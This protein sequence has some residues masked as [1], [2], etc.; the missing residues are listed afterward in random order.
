MSK[1]VPV[2]GLIGLAISL[3]IA[4]G[5]S[6][7]ETYVS[8]NI[9]QD[10]TWTEEGSPYIIIR[11]ISVYPSATLTIKPGVKI[12]FDGYYSLQIGGTLVA[13]G[14][15]QKY[16]TFT[17]NKANPSPG[18]W[19]RI[20]FLDSS[21]DARFDDA[22]NYL[23]GSILEYCKIEYGG[24]SRYGNIGVI[25]ADQ[26]ASPAIIRNTISKNAS[27]AV[28]L[29]GNSSSMITSNVITDNSGLGI[30]CPGSSL[31]IENNTISNNATGIWGS[32]KSI[33]NNFIHGNRGGGIGIDADST[34]TNNIILNNTYS[35]I[36]IYSSTSI[37]SGNKVINNGDDGILGTES[38]ALIVNNSIIGNRGYGINCYNDKVENNT[39]TKNKGGIKNALKA[40][41]N[42][43]FDNTDYDYLSSTSTDVDAANNWWG[44]TDTAEID[45][46]IYD[47]W[48]NITLGKVNYPPILDAPNL[49]A[50]PL[51]PTGL[52]ATVEDNKI[53]LT[54]KRSEQN[55]LAGYK[56]YYDTDSGYPYGGKNAAEGDSPI[57]VGNRIS[58][59][60]TGLSDGIYF[61]SIT[62]Y[63]T[64]GNESWHSDEVEIKVGTGVDATPPSG[65]ILINDGAE[66]TNSILVDLTLSAADEGIGMGEGARMRFSNDNKT[67][68]D[69]EPYSTTKA[70]WDL[71]AYGGSPDEGTKTVYAL[72]SDA[73]GNWI[74]RAVSDTI[75]YISGIDTTPPSS[76]I[77]APENGATVSGKVYTIKGTAT[78]DKSGVDLIEVSTDGG[79]SWQKA[80]G[81]TNWQYDW[82]LP[83]DGT[84]TIKSR[85]T[86]KDGNIETPGDG[87]TVIVDNQGISTPTGLT[88]QGGAKSVNLSWKA[89]T[90]SDLAGYN[91][92]REIDPTGNYTTKINQ[93]LIKTTSYTDEAVDQGNT[94]WYKITAVDLSGNESN[95]SAA[96]S[97]KVGAITVWMPDIKGEAG[98]KVSLPINVSN[99]T[100]VGSTAA[101][102][103]IK[104]NYNPNLLT[105]TQ[106][107]TTNLTKGFTLY[108]NIS[109]A[110]GQL[111][112]SGVNRTGSTITGEGYLV[113]VEYSINREAVEGATATL[114]F[115]EV[116][117]Y[118]D[119][120]N[121]LTV[122]Y[123][124][125][126]TFTVG[127]AYKRG[128]LNGDGS[129]DSADALIAMKIATGEIEPSKEQKQAGDIDGNGKIN[130]AD[131]ILILRMAVGL[132]IH[133]SSSVASNVIKALKIFASSH[134][135]NVTIG[136]HPGEAGSAITVPII[137]DNLA[138]VAGAD[139]LL[140]FDPDILTATGAS[141]TSLSTGF[142]L[143][144]KITTGAI[145]ISILSTTELS[146]GSGAFVNVGFQVNQGANIGA[147]TSLTL[148]Q[149]SLYSQYGRDLSLDHSVKATNGKFTVAHSTPT[150]L[151]A[152]VEGK[153]VHIQWQ[154][155][156]EAD[157]DH[158]NIYVGYASKAYDLDGSPFN[159]GNITSI[160]APDVPD[161][162]YYLALSAVNSAGQESSLSEEIKLVVGAKPSITIST[163]KDSYSPGDTLTLSFAI[164]NP[165]A[166]TQVVDIFLGIIAPDGSIYFFDSSPF[167]RN[168]IPAKIDDPRSFIPASTSL[169]L[170]PGYDFPL[171]PFFSVALPS[172]LPEGTYHAFGALAEPGSVQAGAPKIIGDI[173]ITS[174]GYSP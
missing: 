167:Q 125:T 42:N 15:S 130:T 95:K 1:K 31:K 39:V 118:D 76:T 120:A 111:N 151:K 131:A 156:S 8:Y 17:S 138:G 54:W 132:D 56:V 88:A 74:T 80:T 23:S 135:I 141:T 9:T 10:T 89:N 166:T 122:D 137:I 123:T 72:F 28:Y 37:I 133:P 51:P 113:E 170:K 81:T 112:I 162:T 104:L 29:P 109:Q 85:A 157:I 100:G 68:S 105:P 58:Y 36:Y 159:V 33:S 48:D 101:G 49:E 158:Y 142:N 128:D 64:Q 45:K 140:T 121:S 60:L 34:I 5:I 32:A 173:S 90:E 14:T 124:D 24:G 102:I 71:R 129:V 87:I 126:A 41:L 6:S 92:Y 99:A 75:E 40:H 70:D 172:N 13:Q 163:N 84:Y 146:E 16:I 18:D 165:T 62:A 153:T 59:Q 55:D 93:E 57:D 21:E 147:S 4:S 77:T 27:D 63:D 117:L 139:I 67:W 47:Y 119:A 65:T 86:D 164:S 103:D 152:T 97:A 26:P 114:S 143:Q 148:A 61:F 69:L 108:D 136:D 171:M 115:V 43:I 82:T 25:Y 83:A 161:G 66:K 154:A 35:G 44:T 96:V 53:S 145:A 169:E 116:K 12:K 144:Y 168:L 50:P 134:T 7:A 91:L 38:N 155:N 3:F 98:D 149:A 150:G 19:D 2:G 160:T 106:V 22:G 94:Y 110:T 73:A 52:K 174:F 107:S 30:Y 78:D 20:Y 46:H 127:A 79:T 11:T